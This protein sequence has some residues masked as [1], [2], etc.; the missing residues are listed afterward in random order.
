M[1]LHL[2]ILSPNVSFLITHV[3][4]DVQ[5]FHLFETGPYLLRSI[6]LFIILLLLLKRC[7][8]KAIQFTSIYYIPPA[9][10]ETLRTRPFAFGRPFLAAQIPS[11]STYHDK[12]LGRIIIIV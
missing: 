9:E 1:L 8:A 12:Q 5:G 7:I 6:P 2:S 11:I 3:Y 10:V 4:T